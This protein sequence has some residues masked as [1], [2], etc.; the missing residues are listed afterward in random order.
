MRQIHYYKIR[1]NIITKCDNF[2]ANSDGYYKV[3]GLLQNALV[4][5]KSDVTGLVN[6]KLALQKT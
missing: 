5:G 3:Q 1:Q 6:L 2:I 4:Q